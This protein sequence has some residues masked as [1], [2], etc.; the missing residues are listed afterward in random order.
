MSRKTIVATVVI[1][2]SA[3]VGYLL[4]RLTSLPFFDLAIYQ[5]IP[6]VIAV[7]FLWYILLLAN[8][9]LSLSNRKKLILVYIASSIVFGTAFYFFNGTIVSTLIAAGLYFLFLL[10]TERVAAERSQM[11]VKFNPS[12]IFTPIVSIGTT[13]LLL[14]AVAVGYANGHRLSLSNEEDIILILQ[15]LLVPLLANS[16]RILPLIGIDTQALAHEVATTIVS[17]YR[18]YLWLVPF[19]TALIVVV[20]VQPIVWVVTFF[21]RCINPLIIYLL[22]KLRIVSVTTRTVEQEIVSV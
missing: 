18:D 17:T 2:I 1:I 4:A 10:A 7:V 14:A 9:L 20:F 22:K 12:A 21:I 19:M 11:Y 5:E 15:R 16:S 13:F 3:V 8:F 6:S